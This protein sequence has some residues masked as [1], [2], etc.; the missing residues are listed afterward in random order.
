VAYKPETPMIKADWEVI[1]ALVQAGENESP[2]GWSA[3]WPQ[4]VDGAKT[5]DIV[6]KFRNFVRRNVS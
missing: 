1:E 5:H 3:D 4:D 6:I 2:W